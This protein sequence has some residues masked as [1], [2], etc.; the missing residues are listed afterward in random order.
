MEREERSPAVGGT[1]LGCRNV[2]NP[3]LLLTPPRCQGRELEA[4]SADEYPQ[5]SEDYRRWGRQGE[6]W[7]RKSTKDAKSAKSPLTLRK[8]N[9]LHIPIHPVD[10]HSFSRTVSFLR[11]LRLFAATP[12]I[13][14]PLTL[15]LSRFDPLDRPPSTPGT[16]TEALPRHHLDLPRAAPPCQTPCF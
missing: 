4:Q 1:R 16:S 15:N 3:Q 8:P 13:L 10:S 11:L 14:R 6:N 5:M 12:A 9:P 7:P 2:R